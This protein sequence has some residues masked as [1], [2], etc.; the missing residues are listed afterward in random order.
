MILRLRKRGIRILVVGLRLAGLRIDRVAQPY[1]RT[2]HA[3]AAFGDPDMRVAILGEPGAGRLGGVGA[4]NHAQGETERSGKA[5]D[6][7]DHGGSK[8]GLSGK[9]WRHSYPAHPGGQPK[10][11]FKR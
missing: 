1:D 3:G 10:A 6:V 4:G 8:C 2:A 7:N 11:A 9:S 5:N